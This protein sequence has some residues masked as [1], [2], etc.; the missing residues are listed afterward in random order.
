MSRYT[1]G[2]SGYGRARLP[3]NDDA[4]RTTVA[5]P[6][7]PRYLPPAQQIALLTLRGGTL[8]SACISA[9]RAAGAPSPN[10]LDYIALSQARLCVRYSEGR[11]AL[12]PIGKYRADELARA[13]ATVADIHIF[14]FGRSPHA[15]TARCSCGFFASNATAI[16]D[17]LTKAMAA[18][19]K[20]LAH[21]G[22]LPMPERAK[23]LAEIW[24]SPAVDDRFGPAR[25]APDA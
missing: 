7:D 1:F 11:R 16:R 25:E 20:H 10:E 21:V 5:D 14:A 12:T 3:A 13:V 8:A 2:V 9:L 17:P 23:A 15:W 18:A 22:K 24:A 6:S 4:P 19:T